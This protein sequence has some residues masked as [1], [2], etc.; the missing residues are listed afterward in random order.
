[1]SPIQKAGQVS[2]RNEVE[3]LATIQNTFNVVY[4]WPFV[5]AAATSMAAW[6]GWQW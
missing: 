1:M 6:A 3:I 2:F 5:V 4:Q